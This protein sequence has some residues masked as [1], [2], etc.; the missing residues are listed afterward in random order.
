MAYSATDLAVLRIRFRYEINSSLLEL[1]IS[2]FPDLERPF[3]QLIE[4]FLGFP[5]IDE[6][7]L[8]LFHFLLSHYSP[9]YPAECVFPVLIRWIKNVSGFPIQLLI[10][11]QFFTSKVRQYVNPLGRIREMANRM[12]LD[13]C[14]RLQYFSLRLISACLREFE[15]VRNRSHELIIPEDVVKVVRDFGSNDK[16]VTAGLK[17]LARLAETEQMRE[18]LEQLDMEGLVHRILDYGAY[19][20]RVNCWRFAK[21]WLEK[22]A[23]RESAFLLNVEL[24]Q[25]AVEQLQAGAVVLSQVVIEFLIQVLERVKQTREFEIV[26]VIG[27]QELMAE[28]TEMTELVPKSLCHDQAFALIRLMAEAET[29]ERCTI[30]TME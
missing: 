26:E 27:T 2:K 29:S 15:T 23:M 3:V 5:E 20:S 10:E 22:A 11:S 14:S 12:V 1:L 28:L 13:G 24:L 17:T 8:D 18:L 30:L 9:I 4:H 21:V 6:Y 25:L 16:V 19:S 7:S